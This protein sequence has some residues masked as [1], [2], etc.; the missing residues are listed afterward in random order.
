MQPHY[1]DPSRPI[2]I[3]LLAVIG[4]M[5]WPIWGEIIAGYHRFTWTVAASALVPLLLCLVPLALWL[6]VPHRTGNG[7]RRLEHATH[8]DNLLHHGH[9]GPA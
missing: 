7:I 9:H 6:D 5:A 4:M 8:V 2:K 1:D 3:G